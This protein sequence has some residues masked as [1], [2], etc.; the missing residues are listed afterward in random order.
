MPRGRCGC[1]GWWTPCPPRWLVPLAAEQAEQE[2]EDVE[3]VEEDA[4]GDT[5]GAAG[6]CSAQAVEVEDRERTEN[7]EPGDGVDD[8]AV[9][10]RNEDRDDP[11]PD[12]AEQ[13]PEKGAR[14]R[15]EVSAGGVPICATGGDERRR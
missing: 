10:D 15:G 12:E 13:C 1:S 11:E 14:P 4:R 2:Q 9:G 3:D 5:H 7:R 8:V 6:I